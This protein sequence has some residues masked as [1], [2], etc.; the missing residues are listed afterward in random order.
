MVT[1]LYCLRDVNE[2]RDSQFVLSI[3]CTLL[4]ILI[5]FVSCVFRVYEG[6]PLCCVLV[7]FTHCSNL[8]RRH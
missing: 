1:L 2:R 6:S 4:S 7:V 5:Q 8:E 3:L